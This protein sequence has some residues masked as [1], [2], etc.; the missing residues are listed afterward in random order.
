MQLWPSYYLREVLTG[1]LPLKDA[2]PAVQSW[3][4]LEIHD[5]AMAVINAGGIE[6]RRAMLQRIPA[7]VRPYVEERVRELWKASHDT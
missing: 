7:S 3:A 4:R 5:G 6:K 2:P 1:S